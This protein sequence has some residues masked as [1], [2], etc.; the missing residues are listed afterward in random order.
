MDASEAESYLKD[1]QQKGFTDA[2]M[3][4]EFTEEGKGEIRVL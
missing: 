1:L 2:V 3:I 4:G